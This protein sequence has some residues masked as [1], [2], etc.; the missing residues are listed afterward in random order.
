[1]RIKTPPINQM[2]GAAQTETRKFADYRPTEGLPPELKES[3]K[4]IN[5]HQPPQI[6]ETRVIVRS[7]HN[8]K[9]RHNRIINFRHRQSREWLIKTLEWSLWNEHYVMVN[10]MTDDDKFESE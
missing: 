2:V 10:A 1:M 5:H 7:V 9:I 3:L 8:D 4:R 6:L